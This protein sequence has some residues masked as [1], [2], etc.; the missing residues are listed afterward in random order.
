[1]KIKCQYRIKWS[2]IF[3]H[4][5]FPLNWNFEHQTSK[6]FFRRWIRRAFK[7]TLCYLASWWLNNIQ[8]R[9]TNNRRIYFRYLQWDS[10]IKH[11]IYGDVN[12]IVTRAIHIQIFLIRHGPMAK[13]PSP[14]KNELFIK[15]MRETSRNRH[16]IH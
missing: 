11:N 12:F 3:N 7:W 8:I 9:G 6:H 5:F 2:F 14:N 10:L 13:K 4:N 1:M 16:N 15:L